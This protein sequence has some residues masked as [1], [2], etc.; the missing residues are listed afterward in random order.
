M[1]QLPEKFTK[2]V[3]H[4]DDLPE[5]AKI[6]YKIAVAFRGSDPEDITG[7]IVSP[8]DNF[9]YFEEKL[10]RQG[11]RLTGFLRNKKVKVLEVG[12]G[13]AMF[14]NFVKQK[15]IDIVGVDARPRGMTGEQVQA[16][17]EQLPFADEAF[18]VVYSQSVFD[19]E[20]YKQYPELMMKEIYRVLKHGGFY[21]C[22]G[23]KEPP[24]VDGF[25]LVS[26]GFDGVYKKL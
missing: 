5:K 2:N 20:F 25:N 14:L 15:G 23:F 11:V 18:D 10:R 7:P 12:S 8:E 6:G 26:S 17:I 1:E 13:N 21:V 16:R 22:S 4:L 24:L 9:K 3:R 19:S